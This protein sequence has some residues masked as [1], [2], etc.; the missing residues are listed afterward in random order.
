[1]LQQR[2][3]A[4]V[5]HVEDGDVRAPSIKDRLRVDEVTR[6]LHDEEPVVQGQLDEVH[7]QGLIVK[8][9]RATGAARTRVHS[10]P[11]PLRR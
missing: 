1:M 8:H 4:V 7:E 2:R 3:T 9:E 10:C 11:D 5:L 6:G